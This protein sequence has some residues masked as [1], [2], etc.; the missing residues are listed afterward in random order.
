MYLPPLASWAVSDFLQ[1]WHLTRP[2]R[3]RSHQSRGGPSRSIV[4]RPRRAMA[5]AS[6]RRLR[7]LSL[8]RSLPFRFSRDVLISPEGDGREREQDG[9]RGQPLHGSM[10]LMEARIAS[11]MAFTSRCEA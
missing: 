3:T 8:S 7:F 10:T 11:K 2:L 1:V 5:W 9:D 6:D 4:S